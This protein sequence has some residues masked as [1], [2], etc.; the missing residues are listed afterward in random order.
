M[1]PF[2]RKRALAAFRFRTEFCLEAFESRLKEIC[3]PSNDLAHPFKKHLHPF[4]RLDHP[5]GRNVQPFERLAH[6]FGKNIHPF[7]RLAHLFDKSVQPFNNLLTH[8]LKTSN[9]SNDLLTRSLE[10]PS[11]Q[12]TWVNLWTALI[13]RSGK[14]Y[15]L[16]AYVRLSGSTCSHTSV[17]ISRTRKKSLRSLEQSASRL[18]DNNKTSPNNEAH[19][20]TVH[21]EKLNYGVVSLGSNGFCFWIPIQKYCFRFLL[22]AWSVSEDKMYCW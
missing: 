21:V 5:F 7:E 13:I 20:E 8:L 12:T 9:Y 17:F 18:R 10:H 4:E 16:K 14:K 15:Q 1:W 6:P 3:I 19:K 11:V 2:T 22:L